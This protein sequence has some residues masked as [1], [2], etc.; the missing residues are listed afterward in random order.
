MFRFGRVLTGVRSIFENAKSLHTERLEPSKVRI[1]K[2]VP[3]D[4]VVVHKL[5]EC[6]GLSPESALDLGRKSACLGTINIS[7]NIPGAYEKIKY[8]ITIA[9][10]DSKSIVC[11]GDPFVIDLVAEVFNPPYE[12]DYFGPTSVS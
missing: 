11:S 6:L 7:G 8:P 2:D 12:V 10:Y 3:T 1:I 4:A 5:F 9:Y